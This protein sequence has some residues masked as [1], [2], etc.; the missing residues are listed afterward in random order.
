MQP[1]STTTLNALRSS[2]VARS[3]VRALDT[4]GQTSVNP[5]GTSMSVVTGVVRQSVDAT[6]RSTVD[7]TVTGPWPATHGAAEWLLSP[8]GREIYVSRFVGLGNQ[9][10][11]GETIPIGYFRVDDVEERD[12]GTLRITGS[13]RAAWV[14]DQ[15]AIGPVT[16]TGPLSGVLA[17]IAAE[18]STQS[19]IYPPVPGTTVAGPTQILPGVNGLVGVN[20]FVVE[21][22]R[23]LGMRALCQSYGYDCWADARG[24]LT[25][26]LMPGTQPPSTPQVWTI[27]ANVNLS[28]LSRA[29]TRRGV[30]NRVVVTGDTMILNGGVG[31]LRQVRSVAVNSSVATGG[32]AWVGGP[33]G[34]L[35]RRD[36]FPALTT[37]GQ[38][39]DA[40]AAILV[41]E[42]VVAT[43]VRA[44]IVPCPAL[45]AGDV[46]QLNTRDG[47]D[48][49]RYVVVEQAIPLGLDSD[50]TVAMRELVA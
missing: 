30:A 20:G 16:Y 19:A 32:P 36:H 45:E 39:F 42:R 4:L 28:R 34:V 38:C 27:S 10:G 40:A 44:V 5:P 17:S 43:D 2:H 33:A 9:P 31:P 47:R 18:I 11:G 24:R 15:E 48:T 21:R 25:V 46:V 35:T 29:V 1:V 12:D 41:R 50:H 23:W 37:D 6:I 7:V 13:D 26:G 22:D 8:F 14:H 3:T 49:G